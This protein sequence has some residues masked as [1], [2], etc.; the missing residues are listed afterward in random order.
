MRL[1]PVRPTLALLVS[2]CAL[3]APGLAEGA[4]GPTGRLV[5]ALQEEHR[6]AA[7]SP[8]GALL[9]SA[10]TGLRPRAVA[11]VGEGRLLV[12]N[13][14]RDAAPG[15]SLTLLSS[16][17]L[18]AL[19]TLPVCSDCAPSGLHIDGAGRLLLGA[20]HHKA[21]LI[22]ES[23]G[24][25]PLRTLLTPWGWPG[26]IVP[27]PWGKGV[28]IG[29][30]STSR[31][32]LFEF[33]KKRVEN[34]EIDMD[35]TQLAARPGREELWVGTRSGRLAV[36]VPDDE[37][38]GRVDEMLVVERPLDLAFEPKGD[39]IFGA[40]AMNG[41]VW[42]IDADSRQ[43]AGDIV[44]GSG[45]AHLLTFSPGGRY[46][47]VA[48]YHENRCLIYDLVAEGEPRLVESFEVSS[49]PRDMIWLP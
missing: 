9:A 31:I 20:Q 17:T 3:A 46:L 1:K 21:I 41:I 5:L 16:D 12:S 33:G 14:G 29:F 32:G 45:V 19:E 38:T 30:Q 25:A 7:Y 28:A 8:Q 36:V 48:L 2:V 10:P 37:A 34:L 47:A 6:V 15:S 42:S 26:E 13:R 27:L 44:L 22:F 24:G 4:D 11:L 18:Q 23:P 40:S 43:P 35:P 39:R 49:R